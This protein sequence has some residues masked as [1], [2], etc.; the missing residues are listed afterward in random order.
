MP[1][2]KYGLRQIVMEAVHRAVDE[3]VAILDKH[4]S[5]VTVGVE[6]S[7]SNLVEHAADSAAFSAEVVECLRLIQLSPSATTT[8]T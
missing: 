3:Q 6:S 1:I 4:R 2:L 7:S 8:S 5:V